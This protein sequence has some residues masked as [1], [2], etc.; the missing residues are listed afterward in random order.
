M[1]RPSIFAWTLWVTAAMAVAA[2]PSG[3]GGGAFGE[4]N[5]AAPREVE[6]F[7]RLVG[8]WQCTTEALQEDGS[9][10]KN[11]ARWTW[12]YVLD[13][14]AIQDTY[15][16]PRVPFM[17]RPLHGTNIRAFNSRTQKWSVVWIQNASN[18]FDP[19]YEAVAEGPDMVMT[20]PRRDGG[21]P[22]RVTF[23]KITDRSFEW[24]NEDRQPDGS[25]KETFRIHAKR[26]E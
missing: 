22:F 12:S 8:E 1:T 9:W 26:K 5:R 11:E 6:Q 7:G 19:P 3:G 13:G 24:R 16:V 18:T 10:S 14:F 20:G 4:R 17:N 25:W 2:Q 15:V 21:G 23:Y